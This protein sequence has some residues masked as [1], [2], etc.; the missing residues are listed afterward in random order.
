MR[1][2]E[3]SSRSRL[4]A[5]AKTLF[6]ERG[7]EA[8]AIADI[9]R[10]ARTSHSQFL[11]YYS[12]KEELR[13][14]IVEQHWA[15]LNKSMVLAMSCVAS[16]TEKLKLALNMLITLLDGNRE[17]RTILL[18]EQAAVR[19]RGH[20][21]VD[22]E[23]RQFSATLDDILGAMKDLGELNANVDLPAFRSALLGSIEGMMRDQLLAGT[24]LLAHQ[25]IEQVRSTLSMLIES[26]LEIQRPVVNPQRSLSDT[27]T[28]IPTEDDWI[29][30]YLR[31]ADKALIPSELS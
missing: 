3:R 14:E 23:F 21:T 13:R 16:P 28:A 15:E 18:L 20:V 19:D 22:R 10:A 30:Y 11:K 6:A 24:H 7:Y 17:F 27:M 29:R 5:A 31:L 8:T 4:R 12:A 9:T 2:D 26:A 25:S 1:D